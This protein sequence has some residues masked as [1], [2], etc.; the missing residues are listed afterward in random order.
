MRGEANVVAAVGVTE[1]LL[2][3]V[4]LALATHVAGALLLL[5]PG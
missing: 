2:R 3:G 1:R 5:L 4:L